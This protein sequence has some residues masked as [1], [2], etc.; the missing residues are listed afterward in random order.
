M[1][2]KSSGLSALGLTM[3]ALGTVIG[4]SFFLGSSIAI[5]NAGPAILIS[6][7]LGGALVYFILF[8][9]SEMTVADAAPG[10]FRTYAE[11]AFG[12]GVGFVTG[13]V[14]WMGL[15]LAMSSE[16]TAAAVFL[17]TWFPGISIPLTGVLIIIAITAAN[18]LGAERLSKLESSLA[19]VK[20][21]AIAGFIVLGLILISGLYPGKPAVGWGALGT[22]RIFPSGI[23]GIAGS[24]L[25]VM[26][27]YA[28]F[29]II[30]LASSETRD[31][32]K[33]VPRAISYTVTGLVCFY[34]VAVAVM[35][36]LVPTSQ[37][38]EKVSPLVAALSGSGIGWAAGAINFVLLTAIL[39]TM[40]A[41][42]FGLGRMVRSLADEGHAPK[43]LKDASDVPY[44]GIL[45]SGA[46]MLAAFGVAFL[47]PEQVYVFL[48]S[49][50][51]FSLLFTYFIIVSTHY[52]FRRQHGCPPRGNCQLP[53]YPAT[54]WISMAALIAIIASMPLIRGQG[55]GLVAGILLLAFFSI[56]YQV[57]KYRKKSRIVFN[58]L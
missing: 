34:V 57:K 39:S 22:E 29:E 30:G 6:Y 16:A 52:K 15:I 53:G 36:P 7:V 17:Q 35:L 2:N 54:S 1:E 23:A 26:F 40:L 32:H 9:L 51:G 48:V 46:A 13:W 3:M 12:P 33:T 20:L 11:R 45:F 37:V 4:G 58:K 14:Y 28:G 47:L 41:A 21:F 24:M 19:A 56:C 31:P 8:A 5:R 50:G 55:T 10:S 42:T 38:S 44:R 27:A 25:I 49:S 18:L 43:L